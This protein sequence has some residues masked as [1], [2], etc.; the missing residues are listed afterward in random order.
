MLADIDEDAARHR[1]EKAPPDPKARLDT[2]FKKGLFWAYI[3]LWTLFATS[4]HASKRAGEPPYNATSA[5]IVTELIKLA[6]S[7][8]FFLL[9]DAPRVLEVTR[10][11]P[12]DALRQ[13]LDATSAG[14]SRLLWM[15]APAALYCV[16]NNLVYINLATFDPG[17]Y[18]LLMQVRHVITA[19]LHT[20]LFSHRLKAVQWCSLALISVGGIFQSRVEHQGAEQRADAHPVGAYVSILFQVCLAATASIVNEKLLKGDVPPAVTVNLQNGAQYAWSILFNIT[21]LAVGGTLGKALSVS[22]MSIIFSPRVLVVITIGACG[23]LITGFFLKHLDSI[24]KSIAT[25]I[26]MFICLVVSY[27]L[28]CTPL[29]FTSILAASFAGLGIISYLPE[30]RGMDT[31]ARRGLQRICCYTLAG[32]LV[33]KVALD[34]LLGESCAAAESARASASA[35][36]IDV[37]FTWAGE[38]D[39]QQN[40]FNV[41]AIRQRD[42]GELEHAICAVRTQMSWVNH[43]YVL[44]RAS[45]AAKP[46]KWAHTY[47]TDGRVTFVDRERLFPNQSHVPT[48]NSFAVYSVAYLIPNLANHFILMDDD[49]FAIRPVGPNY[50]FDLASG[51]P[52]VKREHNWRRIYDT[53]QAIP[54]DACCPHPTGKW[55]AHS[56][57][58]MPMTRTLVAAFHSTYPKYVEFIR[59]HKTRYGG[60]SEDIS[61][62]YTQFWWER[63]QIRYDAPWGFPWDSFVQMPEGKKLQYVIGGTSFPPL[64]FALS[65]FRT[66]FR[67]M[68]HVKFINLND[69]W[70]E[71]PQVWHKQV[72]DVRRFLDQI[73]S[74]PADRSQARAASARPHRPS[75]STSALT[76]AA[77]IG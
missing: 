69:N 70:S 2:P 27:L 64:G 60:L 33:G 49:F 25:T 68:S 30:F 45:S 10:P 3:G 14:R 8:A 56:H 65:F 71:D 34:A 46:P 52:I 53:S 7:M 5:V 39:G 41:T 22:N 31:A 6:L 47:I 42:N 21:W 55:H 43:V 18:N 58:P 57:Q 11:A 19:V 35:P 13:L 23:S 67:F 29:A 48:A 66:L 44:T 20:T 40:E 74:A 4:L 72:R 54:A 38:T 28:F 16:S 36:P 50:F 75:S 9:W 26:E 17:T 32:V 59:S 77:L 76:H 51:R 73:C 37:V 63:N 24:L 1:Q 61:M 12:S 62:M 15:A